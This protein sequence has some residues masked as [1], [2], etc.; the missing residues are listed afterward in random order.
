MAYEPRNP[1]RHET[2]EFRGLRHHLLRWGP[3][4]GDPVLLLHGYADCAASFQFIADEMTPTLP[5]VAIDWRG[6]GVS[7]RAPGGYVPDYYAARTLSR[8]CRAPARMVGHSMERM[9]R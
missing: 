2:Q 7:E 6:F 5:L 8:L 3:D 9:S 1:G 4:S